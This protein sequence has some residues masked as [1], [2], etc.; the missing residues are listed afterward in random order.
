MF[1]QRKL[2]RFTKVY[3]TIASSNT[4]F[5]VQ[6]NEVSRVRWFSVSEVKELL[7]DHPDQVSDGLVDVF[8]KYYSK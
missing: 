2:R 1:E 5:K 3:K 8:E 4:K 6:A 7:A